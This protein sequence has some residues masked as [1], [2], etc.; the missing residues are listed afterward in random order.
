MVDLTKTFR[1]PLQY[2]LLLTGIITLLSV[3]AL[4][5]IPPEIPLFYSLPL[6]TQQLA[7]QYWI[8][9]FPGLSL[10]ITLLHIVLVGLFTAVDEAVLKL[11]CWL[12]VVLQVLLVAVLVRM[13]V[14]VF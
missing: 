1:Q 2:A 13:L 12:T 14:L 10:G 3:L 11:F 7:D 5:F 6:V 8:L 4:F 9:L